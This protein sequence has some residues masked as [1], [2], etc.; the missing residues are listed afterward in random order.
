MASVYVLA[1]ERDLRRAVVFDSV[2]ALLADPLVKEEVELLE[3]DGTKV[4]NI[5]EVVRGLD[6]GETDHVFIGDEGDYYVSHLPLMTNPAKQKAAEARGLAE[7]AM[8]S[9]YPKLQKTR[10][11]ELPPDIVDKIAKGIGLRETPD[12][13]REARRSAAA[14]TVRATQK[15]EETP[16]AESLAVG[17]GRRWKTRRR[18]R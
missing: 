14:A 18:R 15:R 1:P 7:V 5:E 2:E 16:D 13:G 11:R 17:R 10:M 9:Q 6:L 12:A 8:A 4:W 3:D